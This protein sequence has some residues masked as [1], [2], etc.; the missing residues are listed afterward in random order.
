MKYLSDE[1]LRAANQAVVAAVGSAPDPGVT[2]DQHIDGGRSYRVRISNENAGL[3]SLDESHDATAA[4]ASFTQSAATAQAIASGETDAHQA[5]LLGDIRF[6]GDVTIL[7]ERRDAI[8][9][10]QATLAPVMANTEF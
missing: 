1:W 7:I 4:D 10:L 3:V 6:E 8:E 5:F 9:W 2:I